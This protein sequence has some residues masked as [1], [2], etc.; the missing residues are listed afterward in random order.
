VGRWGPGVKKSA[1]RRNLP[2]SPRLLG[3]RRAFAAMQARGGN[4][5]STD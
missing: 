2:P 5:E 3:W 4:F 1:I